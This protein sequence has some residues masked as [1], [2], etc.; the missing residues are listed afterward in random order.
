[1]TRLN[2]DL[3]F[4]TKGLS[5]HATLSYGNY[6]TQDGSFYKPVV[7]YQ[8]VR[9][10]TDGTILYVPMSEE[11]RITYSESVAKNR[12]EYFEFGINYSRMFG[13]HNVGGLVLYNQDKYYDP[14][15][16]FLVPNSHQ[17]LVGRVT[18][19]FKGRYMAEVNV[20]YNGTENFIEG[21]GLAY[22][23]LFCRLECIRGAFL[24]KKRCADLS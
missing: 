24:P 8:P 22:S 12:R 13:G 14:T 1:M 10:E 17:G 15:L 6:N 21:S 3:S 23:C 19:D 9:N 7:L 5:T 11:G 20:G 18:Y 4:I 16:A 2:Y